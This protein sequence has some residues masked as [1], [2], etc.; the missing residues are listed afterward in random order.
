MKRISKHLLCLFTVAI[1]VGCSD[2]K[3]GD[4][5]FDPTVYEGDK[6]YHDSTSKY[7]FRT[8]YT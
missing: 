4:D 2:N 6:A 3:F 5:D 7:A 8:R 1:T